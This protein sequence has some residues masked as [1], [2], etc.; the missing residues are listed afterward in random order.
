MNSN[1]KNICIKCGELINLGDDIGWRRRGNV[2]GLSSVAWHTRCAYMLDNPNHV[3]KIRE[4]TKDAPFTPYLPVKVDTHPEYVPGQPV[5]LHI[6]GQSPQTPQI[7]QIPG[8]PLDLDALAAKV[9]PPMFARL[10]VAIA[11]TD[12]KID[13][14]LGALD[15]RMQSMIDN[16]MRTHIVVDNKE[17]G[18]SKDIGRQ[19]KTFNKLAEL[20]NLRMH[21]YLYG[22]PG[23][24]KSTAAMKYAEA[25]GLQHGF[26][27]M[28]PQSQDSK[29]Y[30]FVDALGKQSQTTFYKLWT[31]GGVMVIEELDNAPNP[32][33]VSL[34][35]ALEQKVAD[36][37]GIGMVKAHPDF[38]CVAAGNTNMR[39]PVPAFP[40]RR[41]IDGSVLDRFVFLKWDE[42]KDFEE[43]IALSINPDAQ[44]WIKWVQSIRAH[45][46]VEH[47]GLLVTPRASYKGA[48]LLRSSVFD[49][50]EVAEMALFK[51]FDRDS[52]KAILNKYPLPKM[53]A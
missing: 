2:Y 6:P 43:S 7:P 9:M 26:I 13:A 47:P 46:R 39:G 32:L 53:G 19:H 48:E 25:I 3:S 11:T 20:I 16:A 50:A 18:E 17:T 49:T 34:N 30:G 41:K 35:N 27:A 38:V 36:F 1:R 24:G 5:T 12:S 22:Q 33:L 51:D 37:P 23:W 21:V 52:V 8:Q 42:D 4:F 29:V 10:D 15:G 14:K 28:T 44:A 45:A 31:E 40:D